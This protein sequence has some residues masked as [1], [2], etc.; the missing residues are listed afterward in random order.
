MQRVD[1]AERDHVV[2]A[3]DRGGRLPDG[4]QPVGGYPTAEMGEVAVD[5]QGRVDL[6]AGFGH[7]LPVS[8]QPQPV[9][10]GVLSSAGESDPAVPEPDQMLGG[11]GAATPVVDVH[12][13]QL[14]PGQRPVDQ[15]DRGSCPDDPVQIVAATLQRRG[16]NRAVDLVLHQQLEV[17]QLA[18]RALLR[19]AQ[20]D[21]VVVL[22]CGGHDG[23]DQLR[24]E[25]VGDVGD[26]EADQLAAAGDEGSRCGVRRVSQLLHRG[27][28]PV[29]RDRGYPG[30]VVEHAG[31]RRLRHARQ[32]GD[33]VAAHLPALAGRRRCHAGSSSH[34][35][36]HHVS[37]PGGP[38][39]PVGVAVS[40][41]PRLDDGQGIIAPCIRIP[42]RPT[43][44]LNHDRLP[45]GQER[46]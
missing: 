12:A 30:V 23:L 40:P 38:Y 25:R 7:R 19:V 33:V 42:T 18:S 9:G 21:V 45:L 46:Q 41:S 15:H 10:R 28:H 8:V 2:G 34:L 14:A 4:Q 11:E 22:R 3:D 43:G 16:E 29:T 35:A 27:H 17:V 20:H 37:G 24:V 13:V 39:R 5:H 36:I 44:G 31:D 26:D 6:D 1:A 32:S